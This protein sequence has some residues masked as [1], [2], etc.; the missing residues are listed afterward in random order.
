MTISA[1]QNK[2]RDERPEKMRKKDNSAKR[3]A[4]GDLLLGHPFEHRSENV[5]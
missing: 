4:Y 2:A 5:L 3:N 1:E